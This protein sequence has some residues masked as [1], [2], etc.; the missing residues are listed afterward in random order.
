MRFIVESVSQLLSSEESVMID[1][2]NGYSYT[3][4]LMK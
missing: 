1:M 2:G 4:A 3:V